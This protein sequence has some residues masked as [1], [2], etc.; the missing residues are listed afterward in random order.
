MKGKLERGSAASKARDPV[1]QSL[2][3]WIPAGLLR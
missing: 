1:I 3:L 2:I